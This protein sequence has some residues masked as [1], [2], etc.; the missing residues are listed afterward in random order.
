MRNTYHE[1]LRPSA[2]LEIEIVLIKS[3]FSLNEMELVYIFGKYVIFVNK[4]KDL[5]QI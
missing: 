4:K 5:V 1:R 3:R 2:L